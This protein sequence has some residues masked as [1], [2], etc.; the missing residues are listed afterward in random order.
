MEL[1]R[2]AIVGTGLIGASVGLAAKRAGVRQVVGYDAD[3]QVLAGAA[4]RG[5]VDQIAESLPGAVEEAELAVVATPVA[6]LPAQVADVLETSPESCTVTDV[7]STKNAVCTSAPA[8]QRFIGGHPVTGSEAR[9]P[10]NASADLFDGAT[11]FL[12]PLAE[13]EPERYRLVH[14]FVG[15]LGATPVA[16]DPLA[17]DRLVALTSHLPHALANL[18]VNQAGSTRIEGHEPLAAAGGSLRDMTRVAGANPRIWVDI[19]LD[20]AEPLREALTEHRRR[21]EQL[22]R[23]LAAGDAGFLAR[24]IGEAAGNRGRILAEAFAEPGELQQLRVHIP[25][26]PGVLAGITQALGAERINIEDFELRHVSPERGGT[27]T[28]LVSG[29]REAERAA[30]LLEAQGYGVVVAPVLED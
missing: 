15:D 21:A 19:F 14:G 8:P 2:L 11:W 4:E 12:T 5:S 23:A 13:T 25:D 3:P 10:A 17:H 29:E 6:N 26:R 28:L 7:G 27:L 30:A 18:L 24:W 20:N 9:G 1:Q 22:E 16:V